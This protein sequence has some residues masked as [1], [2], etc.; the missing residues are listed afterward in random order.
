MTQLERPAL[1]GLATLQVLMLLALMA[2]LAP[3]PPQ[4]TPLFAMGPFLAAS[5]ALCLMT[6][7]LPDEADGLSAVL[8]ILAAA[9][10]LLGHGP[11][12]WTDPN[13]APIWPAVMLGQGAALVLLVGALRR[14]RPAPRPGRQ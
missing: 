3:H 2:G 5:I 11:Q 4:D 13:I 9:L 8:S 14:L 10:A 12:K 1:I 6:C 7:A